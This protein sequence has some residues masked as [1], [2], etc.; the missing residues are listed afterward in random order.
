M[1]KSFQTHL[2]N[3]HKSKPTADVDIMLPALA[4]CANRPLARARHIMTSWLPPKGSSNFA[5]ASSNITSA[6]AAATEHSARRCDAA[7]TESRVAPDGHAYTYEQFA[8]WYDHH[9][10]RIWRTSIVSPGPR[11]EDCPTGVATE[12]A[13]DPTLAPALEVSLRTGDIEQ[14]RTAERSFAPKRSLQQLARNALNAISTAGSNS[15]M[16]R[17]LEHW[18][19]WRSY[20]AC[21]EN[22]HAIIGSRVTL[23]MAEFI[24]GTKDPNRGRQPRLDFVLYRTDGT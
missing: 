3:H 18:F 4:H 13:Q 2:Q 5:D 20:V 1:L 24:D 21:N 12:R 19:P 6:E 10:E 8:D 7:S 16:D 15:S 14:L 11:P 9:A 22:A 17:N 23:A